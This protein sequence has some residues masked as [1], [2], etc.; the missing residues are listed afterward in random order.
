MLSKEEARRKQIL[1]AKFTDEEWG[2][3]A[4]FLD[5]IKGPTVID[6]PLSMFRNIKDNNTLVNILMDILDERV[7]KF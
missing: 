1:N 6:N 3:I 4:P 7:N 2:R 5:E